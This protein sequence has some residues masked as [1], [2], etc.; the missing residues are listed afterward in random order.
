MK[1]DAKNL[2]IV[3]LG[4]GS[5]EQMS[6]TAYQVLKEVDVIVG[7]KT[8][9]GL[10]DEMIA[11]EQQIYDSGMRKEQ[12]RAE[13]AIELAKKGYKVAVISSGDP[14]VYGMA[15]LIYEIIAEKGHQIEAEVIPGITAANAA[16][17][18]LG[19]PLM[20]DY[21]VISLSDLLTP[22][23]QIEKRLKSAAEADFITALYNPRSSKRTEQIKIAR[24]IFLNYRQE[25]TPVGIVHSAGREDEE[26]IITNLNKMLENK[27][28]MLS[29]VIIG[30]SET[31]TDGQK[32]ITPRGYNL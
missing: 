24:K 12:E 23:Q 26:K 27:I 19:A 29:T 9:I 17:S 4:P 25:E 6:R 21:A 10:I 22:W 28:D 20:H 32:M 5:I 2:F 18:I 8:Y 30:N 3:G 15:G 11:D 7:Y 14:G 13:K 31:F 1:Q 16:A